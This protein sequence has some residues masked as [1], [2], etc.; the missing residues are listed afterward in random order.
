MAKWICHPGDDRNTRLV[1][2]FRRHFEVRKAI[3]SALLR[4][5][6]HGIYEAE[7]NGVSVTENKF[8]PGLTSYYT[9][10]NT[11]VPPS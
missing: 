8:T 10:R 5:T 7:L 4:L 3:K 2:V 11:M 6:A 1:P 9:R